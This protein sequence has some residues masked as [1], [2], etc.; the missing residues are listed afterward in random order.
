[1]LPLKWEVVDK[2]SSTGEI[3][4]VPSEINRIATNGDVV[5]AV[6][7]ANRRLHRSGNGGG[8]FTDITRALIDAGAKWPTEIAVAPGMPQFV[9]VSDNAS[10]VYLSVDSG[11]TWSNTGF[12]A[13]ENT[14]VQCIAISNGYKGDGSDLYHDLAV[15]T[16]AWGDNTTTGAGQIYSAKVGKSIPNWGNDNL[17][18]FGA[19]VDISAIAFSPKYKD[20]ST[21]LAVASTAD[22][23]TVSSGNTYLCI[24]LRDLSKQTPTTTWNNKNPGFEALYPAKIDNS[25]GDAI[26][27]SIISRIALPSD[28]GGDKQTTRK[29]FVSY[30]RNPNILNSNDVYRFDDDT[31][32]RNK[33][34]VPY[35]G[36]AAISSIAYYGTLKSGKLLAGE[37]NPSADLTELKMVQVW[38]TLNPLGTPVGSPGT[39]TWTKA[40]QPPSGPGNAQ[41]AWRSSGTAFCG[42]GSLVT[43]DILDESAFSRSYDDGDTWEQTCLI[44]TIIGMSDIAPAPDSRSLFMATFSK[45]G[46]PEGVWRSAG[47]PM[48]TYWA[49]LLTMRTISDSVLL[50]LSP[51]Y[52]NDDTIYAVEARSDN[53]TLEAI[54]ANRS[55]MAVSQNRGNTWKKRYVPGRV[56]DMVA[57]SKDTLYMAL[58]GGYIR[59]STDGG[60]RWGEN[61]MTGLDSINMLALAGNGDLFAGSMDSQVA[62]STDNG[63]SF[64]DIIDHIGTDIGFVQVVADADY[65][66]NKII[67]AAA[68]YRR[69]NTV[70][71]SFDRVYRGTSNPSTQWEQIDETIPESK[72]RQKIGGLMVG[73][74]G[75]LYA[76]RAERATGTLVSDN[77]TGG[78]NRTLNPTSVYPVNIE[79]DIVNRTLI[80]NKTAF[81]PGPLQFTNN[82][83]WLKLSGNYN[84]NVLWAIDRAN[85]VADNATQIYRF[86]DT[87][88]KIGPWIDGPDEIGSD[89]VSGRN[90]QV[91][92]AWEQLSL[93]DW[94]DLQIAKDNDFTL[95]INPEMSAADNISAV[96]G[97]IK[98]K[99]DA[100]NVTSPAVWLAPGSLPE[101]G[102]FYYWRIRC[103]RAATWEFIRSPWSDTARFMVKP[104][105]VVNTPYL[106]PQLRSPEDGDPLGVQSAQQPAQMPAERNG[107]APLWAWIGMAAGTITSF[108][109]F[110]IIVRRREIL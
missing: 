44:N 29:V 79:W 96:T 55:L 94:Y 40:S 103:I 66:R 86:R 102:A 51:D 34:N 99:T 49:R 38:R 81:V 88:C 36:G 93:T 80:D 15:G 3:V 110:I 43:G 95:R 14:T 101:A 1:M 76:L 17:T 52:S 16:A 53:Q 74:E 107:A 84:E 61:V 106:G 54:A 9:A 4:L 2:P 18:I 11:A 82:P 104:G 105:Y 27:V 24:G 58:P 62:Y 31:K 71:N 73:P 42:T 5:Y 77:H 92:L 87:L 108:V 57:A 75:T 68:D 47:E 100:V 35:P 64:I 10:S 56:V 89:P 28:Y 22:N 72:P 25:G 91:D 6:D 59:K 8:T 23:G 109:L 39:T 21:I 48:G 97:F 13:A 83:P 65:S 46:T 45:G 33:L 90:Q 26:G 41:V 19:P 12:T 70:D 78:M 69:N 67:Y 50:R 37:A 32:T 30:N 63:A 60:L 85:A 7:T 20:D 98:I